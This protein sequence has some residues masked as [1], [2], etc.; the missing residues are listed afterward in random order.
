MNKRKQIISLVSSLL[1]AT[2][3]VVNSAIAE[4]H[5]IDHLTSDDKQWAEELGNNSKAF[6][7]SSIREKWNE[8]KRMREGFSSG[9][10]SDNGDVFVGQD[11]SRS[12]ATLKVFVSRSMG[13]NLL[14]LSLCQGGG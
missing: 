12:P 8:L 11:S 9:D 2:F 5:L 13:N 7:I 10:A 3:F 6:G 4:Q 14:K 1:L